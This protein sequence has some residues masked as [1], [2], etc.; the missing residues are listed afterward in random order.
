MKSAMRRSHDF[1]CTEG[2]LKGGWEVLDLTPYRGYEEY[3]QSLSGKQRYKIRR[4]SREVGAANVNVQGRQLS[5]AERVASVRVIYSHC[6][7]L[8]EKQD[9]CIVDVILGT[10]TSWICAVLSTNTVGW[11]DRDT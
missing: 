5:F 1:W 9:G 7:E 6:R 3:E 10:L 11:H 2:Y 8:R 4:A